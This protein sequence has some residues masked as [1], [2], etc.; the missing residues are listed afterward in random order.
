MIGK[1]ILFS[2]LVLL[3]SQQIWAQSV[4]KNTFGSYSIQT[5]EEE[6]GQ[7]AQDQDHEKKEEKKQNIP[8]IITNWKVDNFGANFE[9][10]YNFV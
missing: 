10:S 8:S 1:Q 5:D 9:K 7:S 2:I 3:A 4:N 6:E